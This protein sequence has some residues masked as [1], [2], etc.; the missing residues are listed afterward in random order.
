MG[1]HEPG[2]LD[3]DSTIFAKY[4]DVFVPRRTEQINLI[5]HLV[6]DTK[7]ENVL[8]LGSGDGRLAQELLRHH[9]A[10]KVALLDSSSR[11]QASAQRR[12]RQ[13]SDRVSLYLARIQE[14]EW[15]RDCRY[16]AVVSM[17]SIHHL[18][19]SEKQ[20]LYSRIVQTLSPGGIF[21]MADLVEP[22]SELLRTI[23]AEQWDAAVR[24]QSHQQL[25]SDDGWQEFLKSQWNYFRLPRPDPVDMP[26]SV[27]D[28]VYWLR[29][30]G[31][32]DVDVMWCFAG[33][34]V[35]YSR[36]A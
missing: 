19:D 28:H 35:I 21:V 27:V 6:T 20:E 31:F 26:A 32:T 7:S 12:L 9:R 29:A 8:D 14:N 30:A 36:K 22:P 13:Y 10:L 3:S 16:D 15:V 5:R 2:W 23:A 25:G 11:M 18:L 17:L 34:A 33:H 4:G 24:E 1:E